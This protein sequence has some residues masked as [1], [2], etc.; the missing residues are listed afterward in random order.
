VPALQQA[1]FGPH[2]FRSILESSG[3]F[4]SDKPK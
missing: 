1:A 4:T 3:C 2:I